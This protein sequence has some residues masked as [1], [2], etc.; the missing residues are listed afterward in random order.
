[1]EEK[2]ALSYFQVMDVDGDGKLSENDLLVISAGMSHF[3]SFSTRC[4]S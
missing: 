1:M 2:V 3:R 4:I